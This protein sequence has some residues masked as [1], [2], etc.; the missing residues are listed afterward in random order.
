MKTYQPY[1][2]DIE[3]SKIKTKKIG[4]EMK[5]LNQLCTDN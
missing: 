1:R 2:H 5:I 3:M 4:E